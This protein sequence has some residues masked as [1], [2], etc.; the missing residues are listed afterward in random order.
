MGFA[1]MRAGCNDGRE[2]NSE[3]AGIR[4]K[5]LSVIVP[6]YREAS[7]VPVL[8]ERLQ[9][10]LEGLPWEMIVVDDDSPDGTADVAYAIAARDPRLRCLRRVDRVGLAGAVVEGWLASSADLVAVIDGDLQ[11][12]EAILPK[13]YAALGSRDIDLV[14][15]TRVADETAPVLSP[16]RQKLSERGAWLFRRIAGTSITD[17]M[18]GFFMTRRQIVAELA[19]RL[20]PDGFKILVDL[21]LSSD[22]P[23]KIVEEPYVFRKRLA[24]ESKLSPLVGLD[25]L[26][27]VA[28]HATRGVLPIRFVLFALIGA[29]G[30]VVH[31]AVLSGLI[32]TF[33]A[34]DFDDSQ[35]A[36]TI[37]AMA[38]NF[39]LNNEITYR[40]HRYRGFG[41]IGGFLLFALLCSVG[42]IA[43]VNIASWLF[44]SHE[45]WLIAGLA[46]GLVG[47]VW[48]Y[49]AST[50]F[51]WRRRLKR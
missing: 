2:M 47:V 7:N 1:P 14:I 27:L 32:Q 45:R 28:H 12:D 11:H 34:V 31:L 51:V 35:I 19:P 16:A 3:A 24:G 46:G 36:A 50:T 42:A 49:A 41:M 13:M 39:V 40:S 23:L 8:F 6:T 20:S 4:A 21:V 22:R 17:P 43:N 33:G 25:F 37:A 15:G 44:Q 26:G 10:A 5:T 38:S 30:L 48:N 18:S 9:T 29:I